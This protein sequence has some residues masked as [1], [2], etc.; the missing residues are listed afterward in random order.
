MKKTILVLAAL[1]CTSL[2]AF[3]QT[4]R[5]AAQPNTSGQ[6]AGAPAPSTTSGNSTMTVD[7]CLSGSAGTYTLK[8]KTTGTTYALSGNTSKLADH[9]GHEVQVTGTTSGSGSSASSAANEAAS[10]NTSAMGGTQTIT[11]SSFKHISTS[12]SAK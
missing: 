2:W 5:E 4:D 7:G 12:C 10:G 6:T 11:V 1:L 9:V 3:A 8:D